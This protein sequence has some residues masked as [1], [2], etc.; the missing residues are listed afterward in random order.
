VVPSGLWEERK[1]EIV[2]RDLEQRRLEVRERS[3]KGGP[4]VRGIKEEDGYLFGME[5]DGPQ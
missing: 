1:G 4:P 5:I 3:D 2:R